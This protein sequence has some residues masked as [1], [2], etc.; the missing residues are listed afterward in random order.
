M[1]FECQ[2]QP[3]YQTLNRSATLL[4]LPHKQT[5]AHKTQRQQGR[6]T[7]AVTTAR[8]RA[9]NRPWADLPTGGERAVPHRLTAT[10]DPV[11][12]DLDPRS[13]RSSLHLGIRSEL[14]PLI[15]GLFFWPLGIQKFRI[16]G[17][18]LQH[19]I[20]CA[21]SLLLCTLKYTNQ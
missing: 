17:S 4:S 10:C 2:A 11:S 19:E 15:E 7:A 13:V 21:V 1:L 12:T 20:N 8:A 16:W 14:L 6:P 9:A 5:H 3:S 18:N